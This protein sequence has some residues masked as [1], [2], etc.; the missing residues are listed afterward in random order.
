MKSQT[1]V[2]AQAG[3]GIGRS[4]TGAGFSYSQRLSGAVR[5]AALLAALLSMT[6]CVSNGTPATTNLTS[7]APAT[8]PGVASTDLAGRWTL[9][10]STGGACAMT[11][12]AT[13]GSDG[14]IQPEGGCPGKFFTSRK[15]SLEGGAVVIRNH[16]NE[17]LARLTAISP[18]RY[19]G[20]T[21]GGQQ[22][23]LVR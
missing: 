10:S 4:G 6:A 8:G 16:N 2:G 9:S 15:W 22:L 19:E 20:R 11:F 23:S 13:A 5:T 21:A 1:P 12:V 7:S 14:A 17:P 18:T 3:N